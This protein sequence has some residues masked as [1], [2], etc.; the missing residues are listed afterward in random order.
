MHVFR[1]VRKCYFIIYNWKH[2][3]L[4]KLRERVVSAWPIFIYFLFSSPIYRP[5]SKCHFRTPLKSQIFSILCC[6]C[7]LFSPLFFDALCNLWI[8]FYDFILFHASLLWN[9]T[10]QFF[11][12]HCFNSLL[13][14]LEVLL[15][16]FC[17]G[18]FFFLLS[19][20]DITIFCFQ[21]YLSMP[22][23][24]F[25][26]SKNNNKQRL[27]VKKRKYFK[28]KKKVFFNFFFICVE[29]FA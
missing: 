12:L 10:I 3:Q 26:N 20:N 6:V 23:S 4:S 16:R 2:M 24:H 25:G 29:L 19:I 7:L 1:W 14:P 8:C 11:I 18:C 21:T 22:F 27:L 15:V 5:V 17:F 28:R 9:I 13:Q